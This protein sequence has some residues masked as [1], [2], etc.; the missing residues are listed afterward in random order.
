MRLLCGS[1][2]NMVR[3]VGLGNVNEVYLRVRV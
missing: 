1:F 2:A 3:G